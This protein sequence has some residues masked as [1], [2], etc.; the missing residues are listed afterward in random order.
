M[1]RGDFERLRMIRRGELV[2]GRCV[3]QPHLVAGR[4]IAVGS[5]A[6]LV[7]IVGGGA[8]VL[9]V[10]ISHDGR[11]WFAANSG[12]VWVVGWKLGADRVAEHESGGADACRRVRR[13]P[14]RLQEAE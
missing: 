11:S 5:V 10:A 8:L 6:C 13:C 12:V 1:T 3:P 9:R 2:G 7:G 14:V 4:S